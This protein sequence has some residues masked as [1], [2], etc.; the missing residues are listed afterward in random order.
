V[1][2]RH[3]SHRLVFYEDA[4]DKTDGEVRRIDNQGHLTSRGARVMTWPCLPNRATLAG[5]PLTIGG[6]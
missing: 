6:P 4:S 1:E 5:T 2:K 3:R